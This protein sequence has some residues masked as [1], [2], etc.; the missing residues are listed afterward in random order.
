MIKI[1]FI[2]G[3]LFINNNQILKSQI[4]KSD[5]IYCGNE[6]IKVNTFN[7]KLPNGKVHNSTYLKE[8][9]FQKF[10]SFYNP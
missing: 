9:S 8:Y 6:T 3:S 1:Q 2:N 5:I 4:S 10:R 7:E